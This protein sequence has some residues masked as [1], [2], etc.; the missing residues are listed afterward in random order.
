MSPN[1]GDY[2]IRN[3]QVSW[4]YLRPIDR[5]LTDA[6]GIRLHSDVQAPTS[7]LCYRE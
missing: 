6:S 7:E 3:S 4:V 5:C 1:G 2:S